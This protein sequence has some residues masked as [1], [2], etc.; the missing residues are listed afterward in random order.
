[1]K[2]AEYV[3]HTISWF[4]FGCVFTYVDFTTEVNQKE[5]AIKAPNCLVVWYALRF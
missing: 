5:A 2:V 4:P 3:A 1:M